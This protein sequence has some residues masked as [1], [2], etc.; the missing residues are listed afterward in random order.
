MTMIPSPDPAWLDQQY[1]ALA[2]NPDAPSIFARWAAASAEA[3]A[4]AGHQAD[5]RYGPGARQ[6]MD[7][8]DG[9]RADAP[10]LVFIHG[11]FWRGSDK[12]FHSFIAPAFLAKGCDVVLLSYDLCPTISMQALA[13]Q[14]VDG[15]AHIHRELRARG[16]G[17]ARIVVAGHSAGGH[18]G[19][20]MLACDWQRVGRDLPAGL[21][22][23]VLAISGL[24]DL[25]PFRHAPFLKDA[26]RLDA[27]SVRRL[28][29]VRFAAPVGRVLH[30]AVGA[31]ESSEFHR[32]TAALV[33]SWGTGVV[34]VSM[35]LAG[36]NHFTVLDDLASPGTRLHGTACDLLGIDP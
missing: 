7:W 21:V 22:T 14:V 35:S 16:R 27:E 17:S 33:E 18:L 10:V 13:L 19:A 32:Q 4:K 30:A 5:R 1:N 8:F 15:L 29:P 34:P 12:S 2:A 24:F 25:E 3:R 31:L 26:V 9:G 36:K 28:S 11:G 23:R 6:T 20:M